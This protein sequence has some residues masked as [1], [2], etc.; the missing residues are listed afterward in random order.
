MGD[1]NY[2]PLGYQDATE[3]SLP[4][5]WMSRLPRRGTGFTGSSSLTWSCWNHQSRAHQ[6]SHGNNVQAIKDTDRKTTSGHKTPKADRQGGSQ[7]DAMEKMEIWQTARI[8]LA[9]HNAPL[10]QLIL[11]AKSMACGMLRPDG[12]SPP[13]TPPLPTGHHSL[14]TIL[15]H[16]IENWK[17]SWWLKKLNTYIQ[18]SEN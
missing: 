18:D 1:L 12:C 15:L 5:A 9:M 8:M 11:L 10:S 3:I 7:G 13:Q 16:V 4:E 17:F 14:V 2:L 6:H